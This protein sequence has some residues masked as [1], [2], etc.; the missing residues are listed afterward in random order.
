MAVLVLLWLCLRLYSQGKG[1]RIPKIVFKSEI[2]KTHLTPEKSEMGF[3]KF[4]IQKSEA[5]KNWR[6]FKNVSDFSGQA[7]HSMQCV[8]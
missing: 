4:K 2:W 7:F 3:W 6:K 1:S 5:G 8:E